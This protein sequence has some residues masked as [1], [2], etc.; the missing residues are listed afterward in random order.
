MYKRKSTAGRYEIFEG[1]YFSKPDNFL[2]PIPEGA[3]L[4]IP[5][6]IF[7]FD[8]MDGR[9]WI[10]VE[11]QETKKLWWAELDVENRDMIS[12]EELLK[13]IK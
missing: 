5:K 4:I 8:T 13:T 12:T 1:S 3:R 9:V 2:P 6:Q 11:D 7:L 10:L